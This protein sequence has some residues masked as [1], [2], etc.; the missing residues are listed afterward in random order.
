[1][2]ITVATLRKAWTVFVRSNTGVARS[3]P[4]WVMDDFVHLF[5]VCAVLCA[6]LM[7]FPN[8]DT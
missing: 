3:N 2:P 5:C 4:T 7:K 1:M 8:Y 6:L